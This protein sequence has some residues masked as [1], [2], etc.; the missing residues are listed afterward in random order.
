MPEPEV[1]PDPLNTLSRAF[2]WSTDDVQKFKGIARYFSRIIVPTGHIL[3]ERDD[4][5]D[6]LYVVESG[7]LRATY[8]FRNQTQRLEEAMVSGTIAGELSA[9]SNLPR[10]ATC[11]VEHHATLWMMSMQDLD[12]LRQEEPAL[13]ASFVQLILKGE[14][15]R[16]PTLVLHVYD[17][18]Y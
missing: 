14:A 3:W 12:R 2:P 5:P 4:N 7:V 9:L 10:N 1:T 11:V 8:E 13:S 15:L 17:D 16:T 18:L 6:G